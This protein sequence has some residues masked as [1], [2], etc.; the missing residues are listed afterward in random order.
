MA[1]A[2][3]PEIRLGRLELQIMNVVW[4][5]GKATVHEVRDELSKGRKP[6]YSTVLTMMRKL[7]A[8]GYLAHEVDDRTYV[9]EPCISRRA[10]RQGLLADLVDRLFEGSSSLL[11]TSLVEQDRITDKEIREIQDLVKK[12][13]VQE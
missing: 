12:R 10:V 5:S 7:E 4:S 3:K 11:L 1:K 9:Y 6:A 13:G 2:V 8:K